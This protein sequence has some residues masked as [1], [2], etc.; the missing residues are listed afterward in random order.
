MSSF[1]V[2]DPSTEWGGREAVGPGLELLVA[3]LLAERLG[4]SLSYSWSAG[5][6]RFDLDL[7]KDIPERPDAR[8]PERGGILSFLRIGPSRA[9]IPAMPDLSESPPGEG[10]RGLV[11]AYDEDPVFLEAL[12][13]YL[14]GRGYAVAPALSVDKAVALAQE[15]RFDLALLDASSLG[16]RGLE[17]CARIRASRGMGELPIVAMTDRESAEAVEAAFRAGA[18]DYLPKL[19]P[20]ELLFARVDTYVALKRSLEEA[21]DTR[22]RIAELEKLKT[23]GVLAAGVAHEV[24]TPNNAVIRNMPLISRVWREL[25]PIVERLTREEGGS[26]IGGWTVE[27]LVREMPELL[28]DTY[29][30]GL[31]IKKIVEDLKDYARDSSSSPPESVDISQAAAYA[32]RL[33]SPLVDRSTRRFVLDAPPGL[34]PVK[35]NFQKLTQV[36]VNILENALQSLPSPDAGV[37]LRTRY[38]AEAGRLALECED[39]GSGISPAVVGKVFEPFFTTKRDFGGTGLGLSVARGIVRDAGGE[40][41]IDSRQGKGTRVRVLLPAMAEGER[42]GDGRIP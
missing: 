22:R 5:R 11:L 3:R 7:P 27:E 17:A 35:A 25:A 24:N 12:K 14:E 8:S 30:A 28:S 9:G 34:P 38:D 18:S 29:D 15:R 2:S 6:G 40:I 21:L 26:I 4:G 41:E 36:A 23:L 13:R 1:P 39:E 42:E 10:R 32:A 31:Q 19:S 20:K 37:S 16:R 33:L